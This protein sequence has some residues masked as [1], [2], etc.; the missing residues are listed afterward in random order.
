MFLWCFG[1]AHRP[2]KLETSRETPSAPALL[3]ARPRPRATYTPGLYTP[4]SYIRMYIHT[5]PTPRAMRAQSRSR[6]IAYSHPRSYA[7]NPAPACRPSSPDHSPVQRAYMRPIH[8]PSCSSSLT[9]SYSPSLL[10]PGIGARSADTPPRVLRP[11]CIQRWVR[12]LY[13][14]GQQLV[15]HQLASLGYACAC[16]HQLRDASLLQLAEK[17][18]LPRDNAPGT[19]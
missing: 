13:N 9:C 1:A 11:P 18:D 14:I 7:R 4:K 16:M 5:R 15:S 6:A 2:K 19:S 12:Q 10:G 3:A 17:E 8:L